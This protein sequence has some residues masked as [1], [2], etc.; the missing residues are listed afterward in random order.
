MKRKSSGTTAYVVAGILVVAASLAAGYYLTG[1]HSTSAPVNAPA[2]SPVSGAPGETPPNPAPV[3][4]RQ[5]ANAG[6]YTAPGAPPVT[7]KEIKS[8]PV[9][10]KTQSDSEASQTGTSTAAPAPVTVSSNV[11]SPAQSTTGPGTT[12]SDTSGS[13]NPSGDSAPAAPAAVPA[14]SNGSSTASADTTG[15]SS[16]GTTLYCVEAGTFTSEKNAKSLVDNLRTLGFDAA[17]VAGDNASSFRVQVGA[18]HTKATADG[19]VTT[20]QHQG[21]PAY[22]Q[23]K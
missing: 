9:P 2:A 1:P 20:L 16:T 5:I 12:D 18:Y 23:I 13:A 6:K 4:P 10:V 11:T 14:A 17:V 21:Y 22:I 8:E 3:Q 19:A 15:S 7:I